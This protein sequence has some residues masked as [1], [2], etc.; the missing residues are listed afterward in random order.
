MNQL[1][2]G[3]LLSYLNIIL[4]NAIGIVM[5]PFIIRSLGNSEYGLYTLIGSF[6]TYLTLMDLGLNN[7]IVRFVAKYRAENDKNGEE[8]FLGT[9][10]KIYLYI[11][12]VLTFI[13]ILLYFNL[14]FIFSKSL[15]ANELEKAKIMFAI[16]V[17]D[18]AI[19][20][21][22]GTFAA[23]CNAYE[24][25]VFPRAINI[26]RY[27]IRATLF[28]LVIYNGGKAISIVII[29]TIL[30]I[31]VLLTTITFVFKTIKV[32]FNFMSIDKKLLRQIFNYSIWIFL[33]GIVSQFFWNAGQVVLGIQTNTKIIAIYGVGITLGGYY[34][35]FAGAINSVFLPKA[36]KMSISNS[37]FEL[38]QAMTKLGRISFIVLMYIFIAFLFFGQEFI[39]LWVGNTYADSWLIALLIM[40]VY[41]IPLIQNF[42]HSLLEAKNKVRIKFII[43]IIFISLGITTGAILSKT[44]NGLGMAIGICSGWAIAQVFIN[45]C[46]IK[47][48]K[49]ELLYFFKELFLSKLTLSVLLSAIIAFYINSIGFDSW[50]LFSLKIM[51]F[52]VVFSLLLYFIGI[53]TFEMQL[54]SEPF[55]FLKKN[56]NEG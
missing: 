44:L 36:T 45:Y 5:T 34:G 51:L 26:T 48:L 9:T 1:K 12:L 20:L 56:K 15:T 19:A 25:F 31:I 13:G 8:V 2:K 14:D 54:F 46:F 37:N 38:T 3:A 7:T 23:I 39:A 17:L 33:L 10:M 16:L 30:N 11:S 22:G 29:D 6:V 53:N 55:A 50:G 52:S 41:T 47:I 21:P 49:L 43:Y 4:S 40:I 28:F 35:A 18:I 27:L 24:Y 32:K 42:G